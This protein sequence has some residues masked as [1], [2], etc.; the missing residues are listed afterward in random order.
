MQILFDITHSLTENFKFADPTILFVA[1]GE[2][3]ISKE[4]LR[5][6]DGDVDAQGPEVPA[7]LAF[8]AI[9]DFF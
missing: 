8:I 6:E 1:E 4:D 3:V 5:V 9:D 7:Y 2:V